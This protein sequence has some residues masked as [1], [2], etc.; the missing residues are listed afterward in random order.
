MSL[1]RVLTEYRERGLLCHYAIRVGCGDRVLLERFF[2]ADESNR[3]DMAS[4]TK[5]MATTPPALMALEQGKISLDDPVSRFFP[6]P[7]EKQG[8][9]VRHLLTHTMGY[10]H[11][12]IC[13]E[14]ITRENV[15][16]EI[17][18]IPSDVPIGTEVRYSC[19]GFILLGRILEEVYGMRLDEIFKRY[20][21]E[22]LGLKSSGF[23]P[24]GEGIV[25]SNK[26]PEEYGKVNDYNCRFLG[27]IAGNA[28]LFSDLRDVTRYTEMLL[29]K[30]A[31]LVSEETF[32]LAVQNHT[33]GLP[34]DG[35]G[36]GF[37]YVDGQYSQTG[38]LFAPGAIGHC[39]HT[40]QS[41][42]AD[43]R[44]GLYAIL[45]TDATLHSAKY[46]EVK[47]MRAAIHNAIKEELK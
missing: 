43:L 20:V 7:T 12:S 44:T 13:A 30:G 35:R 27:G 22:P 45:L 4:V 33:A 26:T 15:W 37:L 2:E 29:A 1:D 41:V 39:G 24:Q 16:Q 47:E 19:P 18:R 17:L 23:L 3:F 36:L 5:I 46:D 38:A 6:C 9:T 31:P 34:G 8:L 21:A 11:K 14:G 28:G 32:A 42:F 25:P 10:G 40:G